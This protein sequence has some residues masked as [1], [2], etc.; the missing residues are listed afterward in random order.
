MKSLQRYHNSGVGLMTISNDAVIRMT[1]K[2]RGIISFY[3]DE[4]HN[5]EVVCFVSEH[6]TISRDQAMEDII[7]FISREDFDSIVDQAFAKTNKKYKLKT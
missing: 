2:Y 3:T 1:S 5:D 4:T 6:A 7:D